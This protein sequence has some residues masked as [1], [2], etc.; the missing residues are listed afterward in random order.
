MAVPENTQQ[1]LI[2]DFSRVIIDL[3]PLGMAVQI[4]IRG[5]PGYPSG[6]SNTGA[7]YPF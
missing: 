3:N 5:T 6:I 2:A 7:N 4:I 1:L